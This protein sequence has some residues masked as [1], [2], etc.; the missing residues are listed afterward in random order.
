MAKGAYLG[1]GGKARKVKTLYFG[2]GGKA[3]AVKKAYVGI[4]GRARPCLSGESISFYGQIDSLSSR[5]YS[6]S[7]TTV[8]GY[9]LFGGGC[10]YPSLRFQTVDVYNANLVKSTANNLSSARSELTGVPI[11]SYALFCGGWAESG[12]TNIVDAYSQSLVR[13]TPSVLSGEY[14]YDMASTKTDN[15]AI[16]ARANANNAYNS[17]LTRFT[18]PATTGARIDMGAASIGGYAIFAGGKLNTDGSLSDIVNAYNDALTLVTPSALCRARN[19]TSGIS[20]NDYAIFA[21]GG[22]TDIVD[23]YSSALVRTTPSV[24]SSIR[25]NPAA[26]SFGEYAMFMAGHIY[27]DSGHPVDIYD[28]SLTRTT[29]NVNISGKLYNFASTTVGNYALFGG[30]NI[31]GK[32]DGTDYMF[33][34][35]SP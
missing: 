15:Y 24:L 23:A 1:V 30:G 22:S 4:G 16:I 34:F 21:G 11:G 10:D 13:S 26:A 2:V 18:L 3:R 6:I 29:I 33:A 31:S 5:R 35:I 28:N 25:N 9:A 17:S 20:V 19:L 14:T 8:G 12:P 7:A 32:N 27:Q